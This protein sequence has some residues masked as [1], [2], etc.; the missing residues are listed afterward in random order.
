MA[1]VEHSSVYD[2][3]LNLLAKSAEPK[4]VLEFQLSDDQQRRL[5]RLLEM[6]REGTLTAE[7]S[8]ELDTYEQF[9]HVVRLLKAR[10]RSGRPQ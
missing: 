3:L 7:E 10:I 9:E 8:A 1:T 2:E 4:E 6:S 5:D